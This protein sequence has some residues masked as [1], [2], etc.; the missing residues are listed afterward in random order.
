VTSKWD[1]VQSEQFCPILRLFPMCGGNIIEP[2]ARKSHDSN[3]ELANAMAKAVNK[4][5]VYI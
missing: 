4:N 3:W 5:H 2:E 1:V